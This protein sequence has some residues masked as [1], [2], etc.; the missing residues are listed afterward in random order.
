MESL[1]PCLEDGLIKRDHVL[2]VDRSVIPNLRI[3]AILVDQ[4]SNALPANVRPR[5]NLEETRRES[6]SIPC[7]RPRPFLCSSGSWS[8]LY[9]NLENTSSLLSEHWLCCILSAFGRLSRA[10]A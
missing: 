6:M 3:E 4:A 8:L 1:F 2:N 5:L 7:E 10:R 9:S